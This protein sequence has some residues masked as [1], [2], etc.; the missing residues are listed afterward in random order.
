MPK[1]SAPFIFYRIENVFSKKFSEIFFCYTY[2]NVVVYLNGNTYAV[3]LSDTEAAGK[4]Y[5]VLKVIF[6]YCLFEEIY[7][8]LRALKV[9]GGSYTNLNE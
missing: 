8:I 9:A 2:V 5:L 6:L 1:L 3:T 7:Y 4:D